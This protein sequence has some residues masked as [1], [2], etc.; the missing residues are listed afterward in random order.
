M[1]LTTLAMNRA[2]PCGLYVMLILKT[3][4]KAEAVEVAE[5]IQTK[6]HRIGR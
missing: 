1:V 3:V 6:V 5:D 2:S 4:G